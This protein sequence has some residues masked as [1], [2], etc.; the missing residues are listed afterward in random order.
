MT[1]KYDRRAVM[2]NAHKR[3]RDGQLL[4][5]NWTFAQCLRT[6]WAAAKIRRQ[7]EIDALKPRRDIMRIAA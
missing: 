6:A 1:Q 2:R 7:N 5:L 4:A 3:Y